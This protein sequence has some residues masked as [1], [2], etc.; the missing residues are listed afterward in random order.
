MNSLTYSLSNY[1]NALYSPGPGTNNLCFS[2]GPLLLAVPKGFVLVLRI[3]SNFSGLYFESELKRSYVPG[4]TPLPYILYGAFLFVSISTFLVFL[5]LEDGYFPF[6]L[7]EI[8]S[9]RPGPGVIR[10]I[11]MVMLSGRR[12]LRVKGEDLRAEG[13]S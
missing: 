10:C 2:Y 7:M 13:N 1:E 6:A 4:A 9:Y 3:I 8:G 5:N 11:C 12:G